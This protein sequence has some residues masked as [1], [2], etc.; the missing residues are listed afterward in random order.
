MTVTT[1]IRT[2]ILDSRG[3]SERASQPGGADRKGGSDN[4]AAAAA[5]MPPHRFLDRVV[6]LGKGIATLVFFAAALLA[7]LVIWD[8][9]VT[10]PWTR[11]GRVRVQV[12]SIA[13]PWQVVAD[14][15][16][17]QY[18]RRFNTVPSVAIQV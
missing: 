16:A 3:A 11:D 13:A 9:Y 5:G 7:G 10:A 4:F 1:D 12:A 2:A 14:T 8:Y 17:S 6:A 18:N 15:N